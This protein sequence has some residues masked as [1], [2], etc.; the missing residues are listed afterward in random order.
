[1][2]ESGRLVRVTSELA[3]TR[4]QWDEIERGLAAHFAG[5]PR[6]AMAD[7]KNRFQVSRKYAVPLLEHLDRLGITRREGDERIPGP[8]LKK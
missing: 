3:Y 6:L 1:M 5:A 4:R 2:I 7:F 8:K